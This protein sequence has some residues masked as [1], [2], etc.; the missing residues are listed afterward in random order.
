MP[1][2]HVSSYGRKIYGF[3]QTGACA[4]WGWGRSEAERPRV[5]RA[6]GSTAATRSALSDTSSDTTSVISTRAACRATRAS[7]VAT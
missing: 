1:G 7:C 2:I 5:H 3:P 6:R 4:W